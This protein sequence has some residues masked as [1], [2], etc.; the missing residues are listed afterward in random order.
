MRLRPDLTLWPLNDELVVFSETDQCLI[1]LN[2]SAA[3]VCRKLQ[4]G[5][6]AS[7]LAQ[8][9]AS[10]GLA[11][12]E[13]AER[14]VRATLDALGSHGMLADR[15]A[16]TGPS[17]AVPD[18]GQ[19][20]AEVEVRYMPPYRPFEPVTERRYRL[21]ETCALVRFAHPAQVRLVD[22][23]I[24]HLATDDCS[25]PT[26]IIDIQGKM[27]PDGYLRNDVYR[28]GNPVGPA[29][30]SKLGPVVK[31]A[32]W[33]SAVNAHDFLF[34]IHAGVV[35]TPESCILLPAAAGSGKSSLT[36]ALTHRGFRFFSDEVALIDRSTFRVPPVP[37]AI[38]I[39]SAGWQLMARYYPEIMAAPTHGRDD[40]KVVRYITPPAGA[41]QHP[42]APVSHIIFPRHD[43]DAPTELKPIAQSEAL[44]RLMGECL[45]LR[46][47]LDQ[48]N[49]GE[50]VR[51]MAGIDCYALTFSSLDEAAELV[52]QVTAHE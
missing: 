27:L 11:A 33:Q 49:V 48:N 7:K 2:A 20:Q 42:P 40:G 28:D 19:R 23:V 37:L 4:E 17:M 14:W 3:L 5:T 22:A 1:G 16:A 13:E 10:E 12:P 45:A 32:L 29:R 34:Y 30:L 26:I 38:C 50:L 51:W 43:K 31:A 18:D 47:R 52:A 46:Q 21:L 44:G 9:L 25:V 39:K 8:A 41:A 15:V 35:G 24:G 6:P 36:A